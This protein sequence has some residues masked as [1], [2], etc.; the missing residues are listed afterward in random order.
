MEFIHFEPQFSVLSSGIGN[1]SYQSISPVR[2]KSSSSYK[3]LSLGFGI[4]L[5]PN[6]CVLKKKEEE[7]KK[8]KKK[9][10]EENK[11]RVQTVKND[12]EEE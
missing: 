6:K 1:D 10:E 5:A 9:D 11:K 3:V 12:I 7:E 8:R 4:K 2:N